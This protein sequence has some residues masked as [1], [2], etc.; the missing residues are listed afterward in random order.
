MNTMFTN[1]SSGIFL[2]SSVSNVH[3]SDDCAENGR[4]LMFGGNT[5][6]QL[7]LGFKPATR[8]PASVKGKLFYIS[9]VIFS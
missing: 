4:V 8:K 5:W 9:A 3:V 1:G 6:G 7:G 2:Q